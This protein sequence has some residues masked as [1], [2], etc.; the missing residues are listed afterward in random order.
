MIGV[1]LR[2]E[3]GEILVS[4]EPLPR[5]PLR[6]RLGRL[7]IARGAAILWE[8]L[9]V[10]ARWLMRSAEVAAGD[11]LGT[12]GSGSRVATL[13]ILAGTLAAV[14]VGFAVIPA[15]AASLI[16][17][18]FGGLPIVAE[19]AV[20]AALQATML[21][22]YLALAG[23]SAD[24]GRTYCYHGAEHRAIHALEH[25]E[26]LTREN[27]A[28]WPTA[29]PRCGTE[30]L[31]VVILVSLVGF[32]LIG[33]LAPVA[34]VISRVIGI[35]VVAGVAYEIL[36]LL[37]RHRERMLARIV[38]APGMA[39]QRITTQLPDDEM[40]DVA[41]AALTATLVA[42]GRAAPVGSAHVSTRPLAAGPSSVA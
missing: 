30:F 29:H 9:F 1:A 19:R 18:A 12:S 3:A 14:V 25:G 24:V 8:T 31:V 6:E 21:V 32:S 23:R 38:A 33:R 27:L 34:T 36:R 39:V 41:I 37:G 40:H 2:T 28:H 16:A 4:T 10:G 20:D 13:G 7:P 15:I 17:Q 22:A 5:G 35:P 26:P 42:E 11:E